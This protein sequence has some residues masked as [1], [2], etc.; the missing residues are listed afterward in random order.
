MRRVLM[1]LTLSLLALPSPAAPL[2]RDGDEAGRGVP[3]PW[4]RRAPM[5][6]VSLE[7]AVLEASLVE[8]TGARPIALIETNYYTFL[9]GEPLEVRL[10]VDPNGFG[11][12]VT[13]YLYTENRTTGERRYYNVGGGQLPAGQQ[14]DVFGMA[15]ARPSPSSSP[16]SMT[17]SSSGRPAAPRR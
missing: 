12:P 3:K 6:A 11:A 8:V 16:P 15:A 10:T 9:A 13:L 7:K 5:S 4:I 2:T 17:S 14:S 1:L